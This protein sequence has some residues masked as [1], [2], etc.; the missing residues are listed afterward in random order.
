MYGEFQICLA[1]IF[2]ICN[3]VSNHLIELNG[4]AIASKI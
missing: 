4:E 3:L 1:K 2:V